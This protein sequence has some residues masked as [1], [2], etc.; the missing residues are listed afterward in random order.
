MVSVYRQ[1]SM[2]RHHGTQS[3]GDAALARDGS[4]LHLRH[5]DPLNAGPSHRRDPP[6]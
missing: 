1:L 6:S 5:E 4:G 3:G 2:A